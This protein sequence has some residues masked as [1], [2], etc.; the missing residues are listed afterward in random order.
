M[1]DVTLKQG[2]SK[3]LRD[4]F[5]QITDVVDVTDHESGENPYYQSG[6]SGESV[7]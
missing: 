5:P 6:A 3:T 1:A 4:H 2:I 7:M